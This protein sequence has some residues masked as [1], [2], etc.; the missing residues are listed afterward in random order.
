MVA[1]GGVATVGAVV[2]GV[3][4]AAVGP[5]IVRVGVPFSAW[6]GRGSSGVVAGVGDVAGIVAVVGLVRAPVGIA[7]GPAW[8]CWTRLRIWFIS[9]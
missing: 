7:V 4:V 1:G 5:T 8:S 3:D 2:A 9:A 6:A